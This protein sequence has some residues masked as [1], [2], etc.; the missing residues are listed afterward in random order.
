MLII[1]FIPKI[2]R[3]IIVKKA[4]LLS[5][6]MIILV[7]ALGGCVAGGGGYLVEQ[8]PN[9]IVLDGDLSEWTGLPP[10]VVDNS[11][12]GGASNSNADFSMVFYTCYDDENFYLGIK[13]LDDKDGSMKPPPKAYETDTFE[14]WINSMQYG[15]SSF[16]FGDV[17]FAS[18][19]GAVTDGCEAAVVDVADLGSHEDMTPLASPGARGRIYE[20]AWPL[21]NFNA[22]PGKKFKFAIAGDDSDGFKRDAVIFWPTRYVWNSIGSYENA[23]LVAPAE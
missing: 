17:N 6:G 18:W 22:E 21:Q 15:L 3:C 2:R 20:A 7:L 10:T 12:S 16:L 13:L 5:L 1:L 14:V 19:F 11:T 8:A 23:V 9:P 4:V